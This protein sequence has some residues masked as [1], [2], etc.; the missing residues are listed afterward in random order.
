VSSV[1]S[2]EEVDLYLAVAV[3]GEAGR[4]YL[5]CC[6]S[7]DVSLS[8]LKRFERERELLAIHHT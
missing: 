5:C 4:R 8:R 6:K 7:D 1:N 3:L 2:D